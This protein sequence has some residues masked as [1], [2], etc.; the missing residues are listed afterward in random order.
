MG[1]LNCVFTSKWV[2]SIV[3]REMAT[4]SKEG[5]NSV[6]VVFSAFEKGSTLNTKNLLLFQM[7]GEHNFDRITSPKSINTP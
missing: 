6:K 4:L 7:S 2:F 3:F 5:G 1:I